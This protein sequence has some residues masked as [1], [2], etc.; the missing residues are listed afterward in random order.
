MYQNLLEQRKQTKEGK[1]YY[2]KEEIMNR[3]DFENLPQWMKELWSLAPNIAK[4]VEAYINKLESQIAAQQSVHWT[5]YLVLGLG[6]F[7]LGMIFGFWLA[8]I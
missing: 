7:A 3:D 2:E 5:A 1:M 6:V 4:N 8:G